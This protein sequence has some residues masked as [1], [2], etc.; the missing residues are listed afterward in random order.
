[1]VQSVQERSDIFIEG[2][3]ARWEINLEGEIKGKYVGTFRFKCFLNPLESIAAN[4][5]YRELIGVSPTMAPEHESFMAYAITQLKYRVIEFPP[6]WSTGQSFNGDLPDTNILS[7][8]LDAAISAEVKYKKI[9]KEK[10]ENA[11][12][13]ASKALEEKLL[14]SHELTKGKNNEE[15]D[16]ADTD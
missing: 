2:N 12:K 7:A 16:E 11:I 13:V 5:E 8:V 6:F 9:L 1:M 10:K 15:E 14:E 3:T 4:R